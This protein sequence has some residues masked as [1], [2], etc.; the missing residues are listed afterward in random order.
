MLSFHS[1]VSRY[2]TTLTRFLLTTR[3]TWA[4]LP[5]WPSL[6]A[7]TLMPTSLCCIR[8]HPFCNYSS[9]LNLLV[10]VATLLT[11]AFIMALW[12]LGQVQRYSPALTELRFVPMSA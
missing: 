12:R 9:A 8:C 10:L 3:A 6:G 1:G 11:R 7:S 2:Q 4:H 5:S